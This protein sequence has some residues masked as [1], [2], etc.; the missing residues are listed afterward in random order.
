MKHCRRQYEAATATSCRCHEALR[1]RNMKQSAPA[2]PH[3]A[4]GVYIIRNLL[5]YIIN[6]GHCISSKVKLRQA[7]VKLG[8]A[9]K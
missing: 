9:P 2:H 7:A 8:L 5:R 4:E 1:K 6:A 3:H